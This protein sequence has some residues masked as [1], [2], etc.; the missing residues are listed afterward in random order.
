MR[1]SFVIGA[2]MLLLA[3]AGVRADDQAAPATPTGDA[4]AAIAYLLDY[5]AKSDCT[6]IRNGTEYD[7]KRAAE[8][9][10]TK[11]DYAKK[12]IKTAEDFIR[13]AATKSLQS[14]QPYLIR[15]KAGDEIRCDAW[16]TG[17]LTAYRKELAAQPPAP[18]KAVEPPR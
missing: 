3:L 5:V 10:R 6:F 11:R 4:A 15:T 12:D 8:H 7:G 2:V 18:P 13:L 9:L 14:G 17:V 1:T 16:L